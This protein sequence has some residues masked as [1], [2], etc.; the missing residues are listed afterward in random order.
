M[1]SDQ[2]LYSIQFIGPPL[3]F[4]ANLIDR[5]SDIAGMKAVC[6]FNGIIYWMGRGGFYAYS[7][8]TEKL[9][10][11]IWAYV[12]SRLN[13]DQFAKVYASSNQNFNEVIW[14]YP[15]VDS[16]EIDSYATLN[17]VDGVWTFGALARTAWFDLDALHGVIAVSP[18]AR[19]YDHDVGADDGSTNPSTPIPAFIESG[20][21][22]LSSEGSFDK[23]DSMMFVRRILPDVTFRMQG[24]ASDAPKMDIV[25][26]MMDKPGGGFGDNSSSAVQ[27][28]ATVPIE[29]FDVAGNTL[30]PGGGLR[31]PARA[32][33]DAQSRE[34][35]HRHQLAHGHEPHRRANGWSAVKD[36]IAAPNLGQANKDF[37]PQYFWTSY[38]SIEQWMAQV[39][40]KGDIQVHGLTADNATIDAMTVSGNFT[41]TGNATVSGN[42]T[43]NG[44]TTLH[45]T[46]VTGNLTSSGNGVFGYVEIDNAGTAYLRLK[47]TG[48]SGASVTAGL[49]MIGADNA[50]RMWMGTDG[51]TSTGYL[52]AYTGD[53][54]ID[55]PSGVIKMA[56]STVPAVTGTLNLGSA[57]LRWGTV[58]TSDLSFNNGIGDWTIVE[59]ENDLFITNNRN[60]KRYKFVL[61]EVD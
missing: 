2:A 49:D 39:V 47:D 41:V 42:L 20:P 3:M 34:Q 33:A 61:T 32:V 6:S 55:A 24:T 37:D 1:W 56:V 9:P 18:E 59:G 17:V 45:N 27:R 43:V 51:T 21:I 22:E 10:C 46:T 28:T 12:A 52:S 4:E 29:M 16:V 23:G 8:R 11:P 58:Y 44:T 53:L 26:K 54:K 25:L 5:W 30:S 31:P 60:G 36:N 57:S 48:Q 15:S 38:R 35:L 13:P 50:A 19:L 40:S 14:F 7:G